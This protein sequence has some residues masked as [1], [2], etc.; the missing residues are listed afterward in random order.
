MGKGMTKRLDRVFGKP[1]GGA[2]PMSP[3]E[4]SRGRA[5]T[6]RQAIGALEL[7]VVARRGLGR[8][9]TWRLALTRLTA[10]QVE[11]RTEEQS[12]EKEFL[13]KSY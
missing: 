5:K 4:W 11:S 1:F 3:D 2:A 6:G 7:A 13:E 8:L 12:S 9:R 10:V